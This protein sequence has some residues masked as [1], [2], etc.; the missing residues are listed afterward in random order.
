MTSDRNEQ[1]AEEQQKSPTRDEWARNFSEWFDK[2]LDD[3]EIVD[4]RYPLK[5]AGVWRPFGFKLRKYTYEILRTLHD[6]TG[7]DEALFP[8]LIPEAEFL[9]EAQHIRGFEKQVYWVTRGGTDE[10]EVPLVLRPTSETSIYPM[11]HLWV[12]SHADLP[13]KLYQVVSTFRYETKHTR[14]LLRVRELTS[15]KEAHT[16]HASYEELE[17]QIQEAVGIYARFFDELGIP[18]LITRRPEWDKFA[19]AEY[20]IAF[21][22]ILPDGR[23]LQIG[24]VHNLGTNFA[25]AFD[26]KFETRDGKS[27]WAYQSCYGIS[28]RCIAAT[29]IVHGDD[30]GL[31]FPPKVAPIQVIIIPIP[32]ASLEQEINKVCDELMK[33]LEHENIRVTVDRSEKTPG[34]KFFFWEMRGVPVRVEVGPT[35]LET[36]SVTLVRRDTLKREIV[37]RLEATTRITDLLVRLTR[38]IKQREAK[39]L[40]SRI[41]RVKTLEEAKEVVGQRIGVVELPWCGLEECGKFLEEELTGSVLGTPEDLQNFEDVEG[42]CFACGKR[43]ITIMRFAR[44]Y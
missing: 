31:V 5:G 40:Q 9:K 15:F 36:N 28:E 42:V 2:I 3:A 44:S 8:L 34:A 14:P 12:R 29:L 37:P 1:Q 19:G 27:Q 7:H 20:S 26:I 32:F 25:K 33:E 6:Q 16:V 30:H 24:T 35:D 22:T 17:Q 11:Y 21:D 41:Y 43:A 18:Y 23:T 39:F 38:D 4:F 10:L 13:L